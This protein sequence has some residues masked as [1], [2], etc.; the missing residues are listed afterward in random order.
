MIAINLFRYCKKRVYS[1]EYNND[2]EKFNETLPKK[3]DFYSQLNLENITN[4]D[5][6]QAKKMF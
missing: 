4:A 3:G 1:C 5:Y 2:W 6:A